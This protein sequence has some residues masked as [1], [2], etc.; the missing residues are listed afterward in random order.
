MLGDKYIIEVLVYSLIIFNLYPITSSLAKRNNNFFNHADSNCISA[1]RSLPTP[2][3]FTT[4]P[5][6]KRV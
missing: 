3:N 1:L 5:L 4:L 6:P 2:S